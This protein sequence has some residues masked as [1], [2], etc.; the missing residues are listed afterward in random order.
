MY[1]LKTDQLWSNLSPSLSDSKLVRKK[2]KKNG[3]KKS[4]NKHELNGIRKIL[5]KSSS[6]ANHGNVHD[7]SGLD[8]VRSSAHLNRLVS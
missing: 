7:T 8:S 6:G 4:L 3:E 5:L 1:E 2:V